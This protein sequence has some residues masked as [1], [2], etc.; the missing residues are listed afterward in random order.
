MNDRTRREFIK[1]GIIAAVSPAL[2]GRLVSAVRAQ[3]SEEPLFQTRYSCF[4]Q[5]T[6]AVIDLY[7]DPLDGLVNDEAH[8]HVFAQS[9]ASAYASRTLADRIHDSGPSFRYA[10]CFDLHEHVGWGTA[11][12]EQLA[13]WGRGFRDA[14]LAA[15]ADYFG[16]NELPTTA[17]DNSEAGRRIR[18]QVATLLTY[19]SEPNDKGDRLE[20]IFF[21][22]HQPSMPGNW[23]ERDAEFWEAVNQSSRLIVAEHYHGHGF[24]CNNTDMYLSNHFFALRDWLYASD[25]PAQIEIANEKFTV[26]HSSR[27]GPGPS[28]WQ[29]ADSNLV[30]FDAFERNLA[31]CS[32]L[33]RNRSG[34]YNRICFAPL[35][36]AYTDP[37]VHP[38]IRRLVN[39]HYNQGSDDIE[40]LCLGDDSSECQ[41]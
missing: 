25:E 33:T 37:A 20:G 38:R 41:C 31:K 10:P 21:M 35:T 1:A 22:T 36:T 24:I 28:G 32:R 7:A 13:E 9:H 19:L 40:R 2:V 30:P 15:T 26:L 16:F 6:G 4:Y 29:G 14:A 17:S 11:G 3:E 34:G 39:W 5:A 12:E 27:Y 23:P 8:V 18:R